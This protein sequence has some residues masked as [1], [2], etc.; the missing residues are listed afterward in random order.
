MLNDI[1]FVWNTLHFKWKLRYEELERHVE[2]N[3][4]GSLPHSKKSPKLHSWLKTQ[5]RQYR[6][7]LEGKRSGMT[8][9]RASL[10]IK[11]GYLG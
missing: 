3:G 11:L 9:E 2:L 5:Q 8:E 7:M 6:A 4:P 10:L 1:G